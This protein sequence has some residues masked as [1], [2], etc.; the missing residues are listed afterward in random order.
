MMDNFPTGTGI[1]IRACQSII[2]EGINLCTVKLL[3][4][5]DLKLARTYQVKEAAKIWP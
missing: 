4:E 2:D 5:C 3:R 1:R